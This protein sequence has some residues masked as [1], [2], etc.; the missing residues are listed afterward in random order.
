MS[1]VAASERGD[2]RTGRA[3]ILDAALAQFGAN[4]VAAT[5]LKVI[6]DEAGVS[7]ALIVH[8]FGS[9]EGLREACDE[10]VAATFR[11]SKLE[12]VAQGPGLD[13]LA[14]LRE[15]S[16]QTQPLLRYLARTLADG[17]PQV[18]ALVDEM[19]D[20]AMEY[21]AEGERTGLIRPS[22]HPRERAAVLMLWS[23]GAL[24][25]HEHL[26]RLL[27]VDLLGDPEQLG[28]YV[29]PAME[30]FSRGLMPEDLY[31][32]ARAAFLDDKDGGS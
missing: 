20:D 26:E 27:G 11:A 2:E 21:L 31:E 13:P 3:R 15:S 28:P 5:S 16:V 23:L 19:V 6:A 22:E 29:L 24:T 25:L 9:K 1:P 8:H 17:T 30:V 14:A 4:G 12:A 10:H 32:R 7:P 18:A